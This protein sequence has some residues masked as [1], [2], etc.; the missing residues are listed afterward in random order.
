MHDYF[1]CLQK[2]SFER[3]KKLKKLNWCLYIRFFFTGAS[4]LTSREV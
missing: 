2:E 1:N 4:M 3:Q